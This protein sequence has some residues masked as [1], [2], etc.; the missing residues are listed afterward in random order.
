MIADPRVH[1]VT[2]TGSEAAGRQV[3]ALAGAHLKKSVM[4]LGGSDPFVVLED[5]DLDLAVQQAVASRYL[6]AGQSC[7]A[8][9]RFVVL[10]SI[11]DEFLARFKA[12]VGSLRPGDP[13]DEHT[14]LAPLARHDLRDDLHK[15]VLDSVAQGATAMAGCRPGVGQGA[16]Y[17]ASILCDVRPGMRAY[18]EELFGPVAVVLRARDD[19]DALRIA[20]DTRFGLGG[21]VWSADTVRAERLARQ[22]ICGCAFVNGMVKSDPRLPFGGVRD[23]GYGRELSQLGIREFVNAKT[24][25]V[26]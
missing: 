15:Q 20:N 21:S 24:L 19:A 18:H 14:T 10:E 23:S 5:A 13:L 12:A 6:N 4:E 3:A 11:A 8:A 9:K 26:R 16:F 22:L 2:L 1:A 7:I 25:W 17:E